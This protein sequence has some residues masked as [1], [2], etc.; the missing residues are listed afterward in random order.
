MQCAAPWPTTTCDTRGGETGHEVVER[1]W[2]ALMDALNGSNAVTAIVAHGQ[3]NTHLLSN[4]DPSFGYEGWEAMTTPD[5][6]EVW[7]D[8]D[9]VH[10]GRLWTGDVAING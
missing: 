3:M 1:G 5:V 10:F 9:G 6:F 4:I 7:R 2:P 8:A